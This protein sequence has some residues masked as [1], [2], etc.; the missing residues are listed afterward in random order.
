[1]RIL[2][3]E[4]I[5]NLTRDDKPKVIDFTLPTLFKLSFQSIPFQLCYVDDKKSP[6]S[7]K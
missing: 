2:K 6:S 3:F 5:I 1:M 4:E 7:I